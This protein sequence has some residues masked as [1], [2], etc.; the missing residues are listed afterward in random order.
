MFEFNSALPHPQPLSRGE[1]GEETEDRDDTFK[2]RGTL[3]SPPGRGAGGEGSYDVLVFG[4][5]CCDL[6]ITGL[7]E[8]PRLGADIFGSDMGI[9][10]GASFNNVRAL[11]RL[12]AR[13]GWAAQFGNDL[14]SQ[15]ALEHVRAEGVDTRLFAY[16]D[17]P[18]RSISL[19]FSY[20]HERGFISYV[21]PVEPLDR[22]QIIRENPARCVLF[23]GLEYD[24]G[25]LAAVDAAHE[26]GAIAAMDCQHASATLETPGLAAALRAVD[27]FLPNASEAML[28]TGAASPEEAVRIV[29]RLSPRVI[30]KQGAQGALTCTDDELLS[31]PAIPVEEVVDTTGAGDCFNAGFLRSYLRGDDLLTCLRYGNICGGL[32]ITAH[33]ACATPTACQAEELFRQLYPSD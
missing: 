20:T 9:E 24:D 14:F 23:T 25:L 33:A 7:P 1:R 28:L 30:V 21:D 17:R 18:L 4:D 3:P 5:Y 19:S 26:M 29:S 22:V 6:I 15:F 16:V 8:L 11:H 27:L 13:V 2:N 10:V 32:A 31:A 12:G